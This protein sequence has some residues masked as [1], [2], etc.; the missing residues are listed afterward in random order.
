[1]KKFTDRSRKNVLAI[2]TVD[3]MAYVLLRPWFEGLQQAGFEVHI[4]CAKG[5][6][7]DQLAEAGF[8]MHPVSFR[9]TFNIFAHIALF[10]E[11]ISILRSGR[12]QIVNT[13]S[14]V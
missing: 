3:I 4:A 2:V 12:F 8:V 1:M 10:F 5:K 7:F 9:R 6:Y 13:H 14:P 11:L